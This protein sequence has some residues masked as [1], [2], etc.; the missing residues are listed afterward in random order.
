[1]IALRAAARKAEV[2]RRVQ[3]QDKQT[4]PRQSAARLD[5]KVG[6]PARGGPRKALAAALRM[7]A[8]RV[9]P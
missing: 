4:A 3:S 9:E 2:E 5:Q 1:M 6:H 7:P 8:A